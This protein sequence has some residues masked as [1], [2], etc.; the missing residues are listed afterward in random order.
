MADLD[1]SYFSALLSQIEA[2]NY[3]IGLQAI[4]FRWLMSKGINVSI[5][6]K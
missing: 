3:G 4:M 1:N 6:R 5:Y 2:L